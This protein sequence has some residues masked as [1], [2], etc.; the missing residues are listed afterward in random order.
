VKREAGEGRT[1]TGSRE[2]EEQRLRKKDEALLLL[3]KLS[4]GKR[5]RA[6]EEVTLDSPHGRRHSH[7]ALAA[8]VGNLS[9]CATATD[10]ATC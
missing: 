8:P 4:A 3:D 10:C 6:D 5:R 7:K 1:K 9:T 2:Q